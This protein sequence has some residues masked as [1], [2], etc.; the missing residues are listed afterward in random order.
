M[1]KPKAFYTITFT[2]KNAPP[3]I[4]TWF[5]G[6]PLLDLEFF[7]YD[8]L[9]E[10]HPSAA[11]DSDTLRESGKAFTVR[12]VQPSSYKRLPI[13]E[14][15]FTKT[16]PLTDG[17]RVRPL[18]HPVSDQFEAPLFYADENSTFLLSPNERVVMVPEYY[19]GWSPTP[20]V[21]VKIPPL[22]E[23]AVVPDS[24]GPVENPLTSLIDPTYQRA[25]GDNSKFIYGGASFT[26]RG[27]ATQVNVGTQ[28]GAG[29]VGT[30]LGN[31][32]V[33]S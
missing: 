8:L 26:A 15:I 23:Q 28:A 16:G 30:R 21:P 33:T 13:D 19:Y 11:L 7:N 12:I 10:S 27:I 20:Q 14:T 4:T 3:I 31:K 1:G 22:Y 17:F 5:D 25:I 18:M 24:L 32:E 9:W 2:S 6:W 29:D